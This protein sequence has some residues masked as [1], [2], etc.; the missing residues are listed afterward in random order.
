MGLQEARKYPTALLK[1][2][3]TIT[4]IRVLQYALTLLEDFLVAD[5]AGRTKYFTKPGK[6]VRIETEWETAD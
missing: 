6:S 2:L 3:M 4:D 5:P 1:V